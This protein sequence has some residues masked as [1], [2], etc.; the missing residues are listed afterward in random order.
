MRIS[1]LSRQTGVPVAT[2]KFY[3]RERLLPPGELTGRNQAQYDERHRR[4]LR[5]IRTFTNIGQLDLSSVRELLGVIENERATARDVF[6]HVNRVLLPRDPA[7]DDANE[8]RKAHEEVIRFIGDLG[9]RIADDAPALNI[10]VQVLAAMRRL[11]CDYGIDVF[12]PYARAAEEMAVAE[13]AVESADNRAH[14][15]AAVAR[16][17]LLDAASAAP[18]RLAQ[19][20]HVVLRFSGAEGDGRPDTG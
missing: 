18:R 19:E 1:E 12:L 8:T 15:A 10:L 6:D 11:D 7:E 3:L 20:H 13:L 2:I 16:A 14:R 17:G 9:W 5:L 4:R